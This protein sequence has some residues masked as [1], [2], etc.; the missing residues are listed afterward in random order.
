M[1]A[2]TEKTLDYGL[3]YVIAYGLNSDGTPAA[4][5]T[6]AYEGLQAQGAVAFDLTVPDARKIT[7]LGE[8]GVT[9]VA[10]LPPSESVEAALNVEASDV[11][12]M[13]MLD[14]ISVAS[15]GEMSHIGIATD[16]QGYEPQIGM[17]LY[18]AARGLDTGATYWHTYII[19][20]AQVVRKPHSMNA[21]KGTVVYQVAPNRVAAHLW[22]VPFSTSTDGF[23][24]AQM[25]EGW[26]NYPQKIVAYLGDGT[27]TD[28][29][30][31]TA[32]QAA[33]TAG[34]TVVVDDVEQTS[35]VTVAT[36]KVTFS[37]A[38]AS[39]ARIV[40]IYEYAGG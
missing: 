34:I 24:A 23:T 1:T 18:Q 20:S 12:L 22:G 8:D 19:P 32:H 35:G 37:S 33:Q 40:V 15:T 14:G 30:F 7:G 6:T 31:P 10:F 38:P 39:G 16:R 2:P 29:T 9:Q 21:D 25:I 11:T 28:F 26:S 3:R 27:T 17:M 13:A 5:S 4:T 36:D